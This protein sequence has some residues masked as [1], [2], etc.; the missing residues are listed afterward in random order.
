[1]D[2]A[3]LLRTA[4]WH[5]GLSQA[6]IANR[7]GTSQQAVARYELGSQNPTLATLE[8]LVAACGMRLHV[9]LVPQPGLE[10]FP[11]RDLLALPPLDRLPL[12][13]RGPL[14][15][16]SRALLGAEVPYLL[17]G[18]AAA[19]L[20]GAVAKPRSLEFW[21]A[22]EA[23]PAVLRSAVVEAGAFDLDCGRIALTELPLRPFGPPVDVFI[24][25]PEQACELRLRLMKHFEHQ[26]VRGIDV[27]LDDVN[28]RLADPDDLV[29]F[30]HPRDRDRLTLQR[31]L[32]VRQETAAGPGSPEASWQAPLQRAPGLEWPYVE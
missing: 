4:R 7:A 16:L 6:E 29:T 24:D 13:F 27:L 21:F 10:D 2:P 19:R 9:A 31:A 15:A 25:G 1:M 28:V 3:E 11:T 26:H 30:W 14:L 5:A 23:D 17:A 22:P 12:R 18:K 32:R 20:L 8:R